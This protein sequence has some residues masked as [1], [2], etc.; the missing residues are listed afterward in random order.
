VADWHGWRA[1]KDGPSL[2][3]GPVPGKSALCIYI[4]E[5]AAIRVCG[6]FRTEDDAA[7]ALS[8]LDDIAM[9]KAR[10]REVSE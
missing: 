3:I 10:R 6:Y 1:K 9:C 5:D 2:H 7:L 4:I 8:I